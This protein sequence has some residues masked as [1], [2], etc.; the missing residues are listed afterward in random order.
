MMTICIESDKKTNEHL[1]ISLQMRNS[2]NILGFTLNPSPCS[3]VGNGFCVLCATQIKIACHDRGTGHPAIM[4]NE[5][6]AEQ[7]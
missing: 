6:K 5:F 7:F 4:A 2:L 3:F 1:W